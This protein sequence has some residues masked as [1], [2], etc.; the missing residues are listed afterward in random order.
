MK[1]IK[2]CITEMIQEIK[3]VIV[4]FQY[5]IIFLGVILLIR[6]KLLDQYLN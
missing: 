1:K 5:I 3:D 6:I 4:F 2:N